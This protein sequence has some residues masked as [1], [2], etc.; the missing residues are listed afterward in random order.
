MHRR[1]KTL[2]LSTIL[3]LGCR[4]FQAPGEGAILERSYL[5]VP[6][7]ASR[8]T[9]RS[10]ASRGASWEIPAMC[11]APRE[12]DRSTRRVWATRARQVSRRLQARP[13]TAAVAIPRV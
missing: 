6:K 1:G 12:F 4:D 5:S 11:F 13:S 7:A 2:I 3:F 9:M 10:G 8:S